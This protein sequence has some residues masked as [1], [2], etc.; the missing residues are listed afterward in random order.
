MPSPSAFLKRSSPVPERR[1]TV[2]H[3]SIPSTVP[4]EI[5][6]NSAVISKQTRQ[7]LRRKGPISSTGRLCSFLRVQ[8]HGRADPPLRSSLLPARDPYGALRGS[9]LKHNSNRRSSRHL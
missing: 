1:I 4:T 3:P 9:D 5:S 8:A 2:F 6:E 7:P